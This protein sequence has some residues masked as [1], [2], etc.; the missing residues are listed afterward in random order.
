MQHLPNPNQRWACPPPC[1]TAAMA[2]ATLS[3]ASGL[4]AASTP[5]SAFPNPQS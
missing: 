1:G 3:A 2:L 5:P 4:R